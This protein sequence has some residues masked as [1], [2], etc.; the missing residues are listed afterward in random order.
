MY[1]ITYIL[2]T[3]VYDGNRFSGGAGPLTQIVSTPPEEEK[4]FRSYIN[5]QCLFTLKLYSYS[6]AQ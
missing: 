5:C 3:Y 4:I 6:T 1:I 2:D